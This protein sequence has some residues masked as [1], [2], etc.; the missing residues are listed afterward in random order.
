MFG[1]K[2]MKGSS[3][4]EKTLFG[5]SEVVFLFGVWRTLLDVNVQI[6]PK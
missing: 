4:G 6:Q 3:L 2:V 5:N 1:E